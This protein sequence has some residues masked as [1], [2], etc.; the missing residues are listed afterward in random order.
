MNVMKMLQNMDKDPTRI[1][2][3]LQDLKGT[4]ARHYKILKR[5]LSELND[6]DTGLTKNQDKIYSS[7][8]T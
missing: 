5:I 6:G 3:T 7:K 8:T 2:R 4:L 1:L